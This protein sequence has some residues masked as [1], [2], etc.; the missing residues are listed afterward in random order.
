LLFL[1]LFSL[2]ILVNCLQLNNIV[3]R[4]KIMSLKSNFQTKANTKDK[5]QIKS[6]KCVFNRLQKLTT[7]KNI[8]QQ[9]LARIDVKPSSFPPLEPEIS[10]MSEIIVRLVLSVRK[11]F[12]LAINGLS[13]VF[14]ASESIEN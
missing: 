14:H 2:K 9:R 8:Y 7:N 11:V 4:K 5:C 10:N 12:C 1:L 6:T 3:N 13:L